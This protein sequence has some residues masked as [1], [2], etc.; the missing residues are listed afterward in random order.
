MKVITK[1]EEFPVIANYSIDKTA[2]TRKFNKERL[3]SSL[4]DKLDIA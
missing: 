4:T 3:G 1:K 2:S